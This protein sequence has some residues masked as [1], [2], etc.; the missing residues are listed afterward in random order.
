MLDVIKRFFENNLI[1]DSSTGPGGTE[2]AIRLAVAALLVEVAESDY[3]ESQ[4]ERQVLLDAI[5]LRFGLDGQ[6]SR[7][8]VRLAAA[9]HAEST[10]Y[11]QFTSLINDHYEPRQ[12]IK[13]VE[14][15]WRVAFA[16]GQLDK[17]EEHVI[18]RLADLL[19]VSH[20]DFI[21]AK[22]RIKKN[23]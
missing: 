13:L 10:D 5:R 22:H 16:D 9:E 18:R 8:L 1:P 17:Y 14:D 19:H 21:A 11:F 12:K 15:L 6:R 4:A 20:K 3:E 2:Q 23:G 7:E